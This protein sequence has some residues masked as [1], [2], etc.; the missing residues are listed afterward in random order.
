MAK[1]VCRAGPYVC[2]WL[3]G[4]AGGTNLVQGIISVLNQL[5]I[6]NFQVAVTLNLT[7]DLIY[8]N[9]LSGAHFLY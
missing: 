7:F 5:G 3:V 1:V 9:T 6:P 4:G 2:G 8:R